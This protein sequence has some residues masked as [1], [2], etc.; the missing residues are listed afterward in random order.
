MDV[1]ITAAAAGSSIQNVARVAGLDET[2]PDGTNDA[3]Q[4]DITVV[5]GAHD[6]DGGNGGQHGDGT[7]FTGANIARALALLLG[8]VAAGFVLLLAARRREDDEEPDSSTG[9]A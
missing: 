5:R 6:G 7:A 2:D 3:G 4:R 1:R 9:T 8:C